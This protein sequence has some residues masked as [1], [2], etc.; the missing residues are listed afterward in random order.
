MTISALLA[1]F[2]M[3]PPPPPSG[4]APKPEPE[5][6]S[7]SDPEELA[8][9]EALFREGEARFVSADYNGAM[10]AF[11]KALGIV[12][13]LPEDNEQIQLLLLYNIG[14]AHE[15]AFEIDQD[16]AHLRQALT[17]YKRYLG[18]TEEKD[19]LGEQLDVEH[20]ILKIEKK[21][22]LARQIEENKN[23]E[24]ERDVPPPPVSDDG[25]KKPRN[26][27]IG[28]A[29]MGG[30]ALVGGIGIIVAG[31]QLKPG[32]EDEV[33]K[34]ANLGIPPDHP[35]WADGDQF[36]ESEERRGKILMGVG[37]GVAAL[38]AAGTAIGVSYLVKAGK[39]KK[40]QLQ[41]TVSAMP[42]FVGVQLKGRF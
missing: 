31:S 9:A 24:R 6:P 23:G 12:A 40:G 36:I 20:R 15:K 16:L 11:T 42:G 41:P 19:D 34:L 39:L 14:S 4:P 2:L 38:G 18:F 1:V 26:I 8:Q 35:A 25:W 37:G 17:L 28:L 10:E 13:A 30:A 29:V 32:A 27:G 5:A 22:Q 33:A 3:G 7:V 21:L